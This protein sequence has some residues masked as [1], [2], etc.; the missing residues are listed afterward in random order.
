R[1]LW[2]AKNPG[3]DYDTRDQDTQEP[4]TS[5]DGEDPENPTNDKTNKERE[6]GTRTSISQQSIQVQS[7]AGL[8]QE[9][10]QLS[11]EFARKSGNKVLVSSRIE[12]SQLEDLKSK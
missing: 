7:I 1:R 8:A 9:R 4:T 3:E 5:G 6:S 12:Q 11:G 2:E 10:F